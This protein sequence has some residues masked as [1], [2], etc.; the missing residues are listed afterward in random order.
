VKVG[1][2]A[3]PARPADVWL[4]RYDPRILQVPIRRG[5][6]GGKTLPHKN[7]VKQ[8]VRVGGWSG[9][10]ETLR[11]PSGDPSL[12]TAILVQ[13]PGGGAILAAVKG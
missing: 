13:A 4:V 3:R 1:A 12:R 10:A 6:N 5:E 11:L 7:I 8:L 2:G 9:R